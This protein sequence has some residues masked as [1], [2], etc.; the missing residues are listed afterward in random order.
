M[1]R[2]KLGRAKTVRLGNLEA[3]R[4]WGYAGDYVESMWAMLQQER[5]DDYVIATGRSTSVREMCRAAFACAG[6]D[7]E[8]HVQ[9]D[10]AFYRPAEV[11]VLRGDAGKARRALGW[12]ARTSL[13]EMLARMVEA[14]LERVAAGG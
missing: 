13:E 4:D 8:P 7:Y 12:E 5:A 2:I 9:V 10:P 1:A 6:L 14:D 3:R 11:D